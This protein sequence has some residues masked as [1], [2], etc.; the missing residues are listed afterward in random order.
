MNELEVDEI[1][2]RWEKLSDTAAAMAL[3]R[4]EARARRSARDGSLTTVLMVGLIAAGIALWRG[5]SGEPSGPTP[6]PTEETGAVASATPAI[7]ASPTWSSPAP[8]GSAPAATRD[9]ADIDA[10][11]AVAKAFEEARAGG[12][13]PSAWELLSPYSQIQIGG[14]A[15]FAETEAAYNT[16][17]GSTFELGR[18]TW[19]PAFLD[20]AYLGDPGS[21]ARQHADFG[22]ALLVFVNHPAMRGAS[23][24]SRAYLLAPVSADTWLV[25]VA[26]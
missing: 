5:A 3:A 14:L 22:R 16:E 1:I 20:P 17:G 15:A 4:R 2:A 19:D 21:D 25:W 13:W 8:T 9:Q 18:P 11:A 26:R 12:D 24:A 10:A 7:T 6:A 23:Q